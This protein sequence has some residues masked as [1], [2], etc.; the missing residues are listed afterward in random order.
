MG[1]SLLLNLWLD[2]VASRLDLVAG[3]GLFFWMDCLDLVASI[4][5]AMRVT[6]V[7]QIHEPSFVHE[8]S[9]LY[10]FMKMRQAPFGY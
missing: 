8:W 10:L 6:Q 2:L 1:P 3:R 7:I 4:E 5:D 9:N